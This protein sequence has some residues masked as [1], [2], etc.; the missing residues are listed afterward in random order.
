MGVIIRQGFKAALSNYIGMG[1][2]FLSLFFLF[3]KF[4]KPDELGAVRLFIE[5]GTVLSA[6]ALMGT[7]YSI[8]RFFP[9]FKTKDQMHH[10]F[11]FWAILFP[12]AGYIIL[13]LFLA[14]FGSDFFLFI[15]PEANK[16]KD[17][18]PMLLTL[19]FLI[20]YQVVSEATCANHGR[21]AVTNFMRE[22]VMRSLIILAGAL[23]Y[24]KVIS[25]NSSLWLMVGGTFVAVTG[26][27]IFLSGLTKINLRPDM[28]FIR[29]NNGLVKEALNFTGLLFFSGV[30]ALV[31]PK[32]DLFLL[33]SIKKDLGEVAIYSIGFYLATFIEIPKRTILQVATPIISN[34]MKEERFEEVEE[35][36]KKNGTNQLLISS[37]LFFLI[38]LNIDNLYEIMP[39]GD[40][41][42]QGKW[43]VFYIGIGKLIDAVLSGNSPIIT[44]SK[45][46]K[47]A[48]ISIV[49]SI[50]CS[51]GFNFYFISHWGMIGG[52]ISTILV[53]LC[54]NLTNAIILQHKLKI[55]PFETAQI[56][57]FIILTVFLIFTFTG[58]WFSNPFLDSIVKTITLGTTMVYVIMRLRVSD[59]FN[60]LLKSKL[61]FL[62]I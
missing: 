26:N 61:P 27:F 38:W 24:L 36:N 35:M 5:L 39:K 56:K 42:K 28:E 29:K 47:L 60:K 16:Y 52:A 19:I 6:F 32:I 15:N 10:G 23:Y 14:L 1:L 4:F 45:F 8:N 43:V 13:L 54:V 49:V 31:V 11:F 25:F 33:S 51:I 40:Y 37:V 17:L 41:Y 12:F 62:K 22:I 18:L 44:N 20:L 50:V 34:K 9:F 59:E 55:N 46:Y 48:F 57:I 53:M 3:P 21:T 58:H 2:G 7:H 30:A